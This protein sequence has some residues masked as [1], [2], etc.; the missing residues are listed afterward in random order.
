MSKGISGTVPKAN[1]VV[2]KA[3]R[4][5]VALAVGALAANAMAG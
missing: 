1:R 5:I 2:P 4:V 3:L